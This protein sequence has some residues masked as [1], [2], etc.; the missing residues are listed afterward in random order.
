MYAVCIAQN[1][2]IGEVVVPAKTKDVLEWMRK[3][4]KAQF[5]LQGKLPDPLD[6]ERIL[7]IFAAVD[8]D[9]DANPH[10]L[11]SPFNE[12]VYNSAILILA[13]ATTD[14]ETYYPSIAEY[15]SIR[16]HEYDTLYREWTFAM[17]EEEDEEE[18]EEEEE[19][20]VPPPVR[21][22][23]ARVVAKVVVRDVFVEC[24]VRVIAVE[25]LEKVLGERAA[26]FEEHVLRHGVALANAEEYDVSWSNRGFWNMYRARVVSL[27]ENLRNKLPDVPL[28]RLATMTAV[29]LCPERWEDTIQLVRST[30]RNLYTQKS[31]S[32]SM[33]C[34]RCKKK[35]PC[36]YVQAQTRSADEP[37][38]T[39]ATCLECGKNW[40]F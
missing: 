29:E 17:D 14:D 35:C 9:A 5:Q 40:K 28:E 25:L 39:F 12:E 30:E 23:P 27:Y 37:M 34:T 10:I 8:E 6:D 21:V 18:E 4:Y 32:A 16:S 3:K 7:N 31:G 26:E 15:T 11:P 22:A 36:D 20:E 1:G 19:E 24:A 2:T 33:W 38:T 13:S